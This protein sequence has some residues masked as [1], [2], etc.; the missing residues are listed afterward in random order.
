MKFSK[1]NQPKKNRKAVK[2]T[3]Y[4]LMRYAQE[5]GNAGLYNE[6]CY[7][8]GNIDLFVPVNTSRNAPNETEE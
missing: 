5:T 1:S 8:T 4:E 2:R 6:M 7:Q 3:P